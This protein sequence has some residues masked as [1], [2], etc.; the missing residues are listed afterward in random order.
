MRRSI[1][2]L[3]SASVLATVP[4]LAIAQDGW[5][6]DRALN[7]GQFDNPPEVAADACE[8]YLD[9]GYEH[10]DYEFLNDVEDERGVVW[11]WDVDSDATPTDGG[12]IWSSY[13]GTDYFKISSSEHSSLIVVKELWQRE[14]EDSRRRS[15]EE[16]RVTFW[17][18]KVSQETV[19]LALWAELGKYLAPPSVHFPAEDPEHHWLYVKVPMEIRVADVPSVRLRAHAEN[20]TGSVDAYITALPTHVVFRPGDFDT[21]PVTCDVTSATADYL[22]PQ[23]PSGCLVVYHNSSA[24]W[25]GA[26]FGTQTELWYDVDTSS[27]VYTGS[28]VATYAQRAVSVA[29][30]QAV[31]VHG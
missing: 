2:C 10:L 27:G 25:P 11:T 16:S 15:L 20:L 4:S 8:P 1:G 18:N 12:M 6:Y 30:I 22:G 24:I 19:V 29:E 14:C 17:V 9:L 26:Q 5:V 21:A 3:V 28:P 13:D 23:E 31:V 7:F